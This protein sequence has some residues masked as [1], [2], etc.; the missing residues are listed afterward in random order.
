VPH[1][2][3][4]DAD[5]STRLVQKGSV[6]VPEDMPADTGQ[7]DLLTGGLENLL[8][9]HPRVVAIARDVG[10][11]DTPARLRTLQVLQKSSEFRVKGTS[12]LEA[13]VLTFP[14]RPL[15]TPC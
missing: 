3:L 2:F 4:L 12:S 13:S 14:I 15:T 9:N 1:E 10:R 5:W 6:R 11:E 8:L 7:A